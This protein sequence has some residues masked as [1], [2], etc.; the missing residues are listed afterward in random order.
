MIEYTHIITIVSVLVTISTIIY[1]RYAYRKLMKRHIAKTEESILT[2]LKINK[3]VAKMKSD[4]DATNLYMA[5]AIMDRDYI[6]EQILDKVIDVAKKHEFNSTEYE[7]A[8]RFFN[9]FV[10]FVSEF[11]KK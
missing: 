3:M 4:N 9:S 7:K 5:G 6:P 1:A 2:I 8:M 11:D 10:S